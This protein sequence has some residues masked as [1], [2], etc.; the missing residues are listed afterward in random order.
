MTSTYQLLVQLEDIDSDTHPELL[1]EYRDPEQPTADPEEST[2]DPE[3]PAAKT[4]E[5]V[6]AVLVR[7]SKNDGIYDIVANNTDANG[8]G[9]SNDD[10]KRL[11]L[12]FAQAAAHLFRAF[13]PQ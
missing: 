12:D 2:A 4:T 5:T 6:H 8:D 7:S 10:D 13:K 11:L 1:I 9:K 3:K